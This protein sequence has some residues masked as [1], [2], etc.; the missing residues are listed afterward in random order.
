MEYHYPIDP[1]WSTEEVI[2][3][4]EFFQLVEQAYEKD[5]RADQVLDQYKLLKQVVPS[6]AEEKTL[7]KD[8]EKQSGY[9]PYKVVQA[10]KQADGSEKIYLR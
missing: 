2:N 1:D 8:F 6:K 4:V 9:V 3:V 5:V 10:A 7:F